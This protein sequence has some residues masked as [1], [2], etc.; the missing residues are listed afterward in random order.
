MGTECGCC[1]AHRYHLFG[2]ALGRH[3]LRLPVL[4]DRD[5]PTLLAVVAPTVQHYLTGPRGRPEPATT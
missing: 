1:A 5:L 4:A 2:I 3:L